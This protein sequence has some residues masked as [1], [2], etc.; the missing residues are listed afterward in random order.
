[1]GE[2]FDCAQLLGFQAALELDKAYCRDYWQ[3]GRI[4]VCLFDADKKPIRDD[5]SSRKYHLFCF[6]YEVKRSSFH[7][8]TN[9]AWV[10]IIQHIN[11]CNVFYQNRTYLGRVLYARVAALIPEHRERSKAMQSKKGIS[12]ATASNKAVKP[13]SGKG[14]PAPPKKKK[15]GKR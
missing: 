4:R 13:P 8:T 7:Q 11:P 5:I 9:R 15:K 10:S 12:K 1:M 3:R 6:P 2:I 14:A